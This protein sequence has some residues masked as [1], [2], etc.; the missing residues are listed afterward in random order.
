MALKGSLQAHRAWPVCEEGQGP[1][2]VL[3]PADTR[4]PSESMGQESN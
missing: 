2:C 1:F 4:S 3:G